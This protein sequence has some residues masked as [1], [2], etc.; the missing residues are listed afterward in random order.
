MLINLQL[1][2]YTHT[3]NLIQISDKTLKVVFK[4]NKDL[5]EE[6]KSM[7]GAKWDPDCRI[8]TIS[9]TKR[10]RYSLYML[11]H[12]NVDL[13][14][15][16]PVIL[17]KASR[18]EC[19]KH[20][21]LMFSWVKQKKRCVIAGEMGTG[22][23]L[24]GIECMEYFGGEWWI[25]CPKTAKLV[26]E[27]EF[28]KWKANKN[29]FTYRLINFNKAE[30]MLLSK[31]RPNH[32][33]AD[34]AHKIK[35]PEAKRSQALL[36]L[37][38]LTT[39]CVIPMTG[40][41]APKDPTD[42]WMLIELCQPGYIRES[43]KIKLS[44]R[45]GIHETNVNQGGQTYSKLVGWREDEVS[46]FYNRVSNI[47]LPIFKKDCL[48]LPEKIYIE[49]EL[50]LDEATKRNI[51]MLQLVEGNGLKL[52]NKLRQ[53]SDGFQ[54]HG[55]CGDCNGVGKQKGCISDCTSC[56]GTGE[57]V[58]PIDTPKDEV[59]K[60]YLDDDSY[61]RFAIYAAYTASVDKLVKIGQELGWTTIRIDGRGIESPFDNP[62]DVFQSD[63]EQ[64]ILFVG[65]SDA[66]GLSITLN[67][68]E[69]LMFYSNSFNGAN[70]MQTEDRIHRIGTTRANIID[71]LWLPTDRYVLDNLQ[72]K[73]ELQSITL[74]EIE[75]INQ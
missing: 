14:Y 65:Q 28:R 5:I 53:Y 32:I 61:N 6:I 58:N 60:E 51:R 41:P 57:I 69:N 18:I 46:K 43:S 26:W 39:G 16:A 29:K 11:E 47:V 15:D 42:L 52:L 22:K 7:E 49:R 68:S 20:Q 25:F 33:L 3:I 23:T 63:T 19:K 13:V 35:N 44:K 73:R 56:G 67:K 62:L 54:Y 48:D 12:G 55:S 38:Q 37:S 21:H 40:T 74:G 4:Y 59:V 34:E 2:G 66:G 70:R 50:P 31:S 24:F 45:L 1:K 36:L 71:L 8:W 10:N 17:N 75:R 27:S 30:E 64:R 72:R 9:D